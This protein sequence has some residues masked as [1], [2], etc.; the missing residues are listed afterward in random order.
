MEIDG[1]EYESGR[2]YFE[3]KTVELMDQV[4]AWDKETMKKIDRTYRDLYKEL[5]SEITDLLSR[6][7]SGGEI[8]YE[9]MNKFN[10]LERLEKQIYDILKKYSKK[11]ADLIREALTEYFME[12]VQFQAE[13]LS[14][15]ANKQM[16]VRFNQKQVEAAINFPWAAYNFETRIGE[17][18]R[19][20]GYT[21]NEVLITGLLEGRSIQKMTR[22][23]LQKINMAKKVAERLI[24]T[25][26]A[27][28]ANLA[29]MHTYKENKVTRVGW[30]LGPEVNRNSPC[31]ACKQHRGK[32][33]SIDKVPTIPVHPNCRCAIYAVEMELSD[34]RI[35][36]L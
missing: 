10:R 6:Y 36:K 33:Y 31:S 30:L 19:R 29:T 20:L 11:E 35:V 14:T 32:T 24:R 2:D 34:G 23:L 22:D 28:I 3:E 7:S 8:T 21:L 12:S 15:F 4:D 17:Q 1:K 25:E 16:P 27:R 18:K 9:M 5:V 26:S 13:V